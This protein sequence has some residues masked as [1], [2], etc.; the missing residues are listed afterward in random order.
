MYAEYK[1]NENT[2]QKNK[3]KT[4]SGDTVPTRTQAHTHTGY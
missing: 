4:V 1:F 2:L 3:G